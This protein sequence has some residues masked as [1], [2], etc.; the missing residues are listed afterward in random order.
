MV[1]RGH[2]P[3]GGTWALP[4]GLV[5]SGETLVEAVVRRLGEETGLAAIC[6]ALVGVNEMVGD[7]QHLVILVYDAV[8]LDPMPIAAGSGAAEAA[9]VNSDEI[10]DLE[11]APGVAEFLHDHG[12]IDVLT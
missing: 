12:V 11:L 1:R 10:I 5:A 9:W 7:E 4:G 3:A 2:G 6:E 8:V